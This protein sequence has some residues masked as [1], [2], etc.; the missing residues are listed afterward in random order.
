MDILPSLVGPR[1]KIDP[2]EDLVMVVDPDS[3]DPIPRIAHSKDGCHLEEEA[4]LLEG[5]V[6]LREDQ[7]VALVVLEVIPEDQGM[8]LGEEE[9]DQVD[10]E[11]EDHRV[12]VPIEGI[13]CLVM[14]VAR[15]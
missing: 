7:G 10:Q 3:M 12:A 8:V 14:G 6:T 2:E 1:V 11:M 15:S 5:L 9:E 13:V 4:P